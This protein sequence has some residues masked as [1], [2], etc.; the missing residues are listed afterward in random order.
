MTNE[1]KFTKRE[2]KLHQ[3]WEAHNT[4][5][6]VPVDSSQY[7]FDSD[8]RKRKF[9]EDI[10]LKLWDIAN[11]NTEGTA[12]RRNKAGELEGGL[13]FMGSSIGDLDDNMI[14]LMAGII[15]NQL[16]SD[17]PDAWKTISADDKYGRAMG[18][19]KMESMIDFLIKTAKKKSKRGS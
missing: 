5:V 13:T 9:A 4:K 6:N 3:Q 15:G 18:R 1:V 12:R 11:T 10:I 19:D 7:S 8:E 14:E 16:E 2:E 17:D